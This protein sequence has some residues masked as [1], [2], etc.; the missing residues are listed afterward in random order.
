MRCSCQKSWKSTCHWSEWQAGKTESKLMVLIH[1]NGNLQDLIM[2]T[3]C[4]HQRPAW[5]G[6]LNKV[7]PP[8]MKTMQSWP[9]VWQCRWKQSSTSSAGLPQEVT[10]TVRPRMP[11]SSQIQWTCYKVKSGIRS[12]DWN[13]HPCLMAT[14]RNS[15][16]MYCPGHIRVKGKDKQIRLAGKATITS[17][18]HPR[19]YEV[20]RSLRHCLQ[21]QRQG[22]H[23]INHLGREVWKEEAL[24]NFPWKDEKRLLSIRWKLELFQRQ[25]WENFWKMGWSTYT[26]LNWTVLIFFHTLDYVTSQKPNCKHWFRTPFLQPLL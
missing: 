22:C 13:M 16:W 20:L 2:Y 8:S 10:L 18:L 5:V 24:D 19:R 6:Y 7:R 1:K 12:P 3:D 26:S 17:G 23:T 25:H 11:S 14:I 4:C 21:V 15:S 9:L